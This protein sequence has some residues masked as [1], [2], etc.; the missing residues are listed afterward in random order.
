MSIASK[1]HNPGCIKNDPNNMWRGSTG[2]DPAGH[3]IFEKVR[4][5]FRAMLISIAKKERNGKFTIL[6]LM[7]DWSPQNDTIGSI[8]G[9]KPNRPDKYAEFVAKRAGIGTKE[10][11]DIFDDATGA[12]RPESV[13][14]LI[15]IYR[16][17]ERMESGGDYYAPAS[18]LLYGAAL[19]Y[20]DR[21]EVNR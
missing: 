8:A 19:Y 4:W 14:L 16:A 3:A 21:V 10:Q 18:E 5:C 12:I 20:E 7:Y 6:K 15:A 13:P 9:G 11:F 17:I 2:S 1:Y